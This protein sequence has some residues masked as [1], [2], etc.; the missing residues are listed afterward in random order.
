[1]PAPGYVAPLRRGPFLCCPVH[2]RHALSAP[3]FSSPPS[4]V[5]AP[6]ERPSPRH[7]AKR[8]APPDS[9]NVG[10]VLGTNAE[11]VEECGHF[12]FGAALCEKVH[13]L[14][15]LPPDVDR[16]DMPSSGRFMPCVCGGRAVEYLHNSITIELLCITDFGRFYLK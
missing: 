12:H 8:H 5:E 11:G 3:V 14:G 10:D 4:G 13:R 2:V 1:M 9:G 7:R 6:H 16:L 15:V